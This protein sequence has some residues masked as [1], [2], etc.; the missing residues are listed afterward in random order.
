[1]VNLQAT[2]SRIAAACGTG[3]FNT[4]A[5]GLDSLFDSATNAIAA[6]TV[7]LAHRLSDEDHPTQGATG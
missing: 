7:L 4:I 5:D 3:F 2:S 1:M 6:V